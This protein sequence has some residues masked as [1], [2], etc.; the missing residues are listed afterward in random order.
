LKRTTQKH[1]AAPH[2]FAGALARRTGLRQVRFAVPARDY[3]PVARAKLR[4]GTVAVARLLACL[5]RQVLTL[6][7]TAARK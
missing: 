6:C 2:T 4:F 7:R 5:C 1:A 3:P